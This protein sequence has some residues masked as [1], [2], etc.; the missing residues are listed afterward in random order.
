MQSK[1]RV[2]KVSIGMPVYNGEPF[3]REALDSLLAQT[4]TDFELIISDNASTDG[5]E[6]I[7]REYASK[8]ARIRYVRQEENRG[9]LSN[10]KFVLDEAVGE[11]F[12]WAASDDKWAPIF[13]HQNYQNLINNASCIGSI[14]KTIFFDGK[15]T[16]YESHTNFPLRGELKQ[17]MKLFLNNPADNSRFYSLFK[18]NVLLHLDLTSYRFHAADWFV[19][20][21]IIR[22]GDL[23]YLDEPML[24]RKIAPKNKYKLAE[25]QDNA[26]NISFGF[27]LLPLTKRLLKNLPFPVFMTCFRE[28][29]KMNA[30]HFF[31]YRIRGIFIL[32]ILK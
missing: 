24:Y 26:G 18:R 25:R 3:I 2:P 20:A 9:A 15:K 7:C 6:A 4:F 32:K 12:M 23:C 13:I 11:Y 14:G 16:F 22:H 17:R 27:P 31:D 28:V 21:E 8:D 5:T 10:F 29:L 19:V 30:K 1:I